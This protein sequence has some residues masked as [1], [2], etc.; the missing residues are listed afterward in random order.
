[1]G[2]WL[3]KVSSGSIKTFRKKNNSSNNGKLKAMDSIAFIKDQYPKN[4]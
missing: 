1:M 4:G 3:L 2:S